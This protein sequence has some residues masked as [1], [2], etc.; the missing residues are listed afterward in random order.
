MEHLFDA[1]IES[2][3]SIQDAIQ[4]KVVYS[5]GQPGG[6]AVGVVVHQRKSG[7]IGAFLR[8]QPLAK[9]LHEGCFSSAQFAVERHFSTLA[10]GLCYFGYCFFQVQ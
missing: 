7:T 4:V 9:G 1:E 3:L 2:F 8:A 6:I 5:S 10:Q